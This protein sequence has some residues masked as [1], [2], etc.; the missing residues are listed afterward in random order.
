M[1]TLFSRLQVRPV[2]FLAG[3]LTRWPEERH[4]EE[5]PRQTPPLPQVC[6]VCLFGQD[7]R[8]TLC[9]PLSR[10]CVQA[11]VDWRSAVVRELHHSERVYVARLNAVL[12]V[13]LPIRPITFCNLF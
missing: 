12:K 6:V 13:R 4:S 8:R 9:P 1:L 2:E 5:G 3:F 10:A 11:D 7:R